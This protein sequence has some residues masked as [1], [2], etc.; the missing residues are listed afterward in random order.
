M[1]VLNTHICNIYLYVCIYVHIYYVYALK[2]L[3]CA[4]SHAR[5]QLNAPQAA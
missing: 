1:Y 4:N 3:S 5:L 2:Q